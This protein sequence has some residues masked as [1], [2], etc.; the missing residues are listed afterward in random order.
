MADSYIP[1]KLYVST[2]EILKRA[3]LKCPFIRI[4]RLFTQL[5]LQFLAYF[6]L[7]KPRISGNYRE[8]SFLYNTRRL[9]TRDCSP[10]MVEPVFF[11][12]I[13]SISRLLLSEYLNVSQFAVFQRDTAFILRLFIV[14]TPKHR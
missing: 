8:H 4:E 5:S 1:R 2:Y 11:A 14:Q 7:I 10:F 12:I 13:F 9:P 6:F 3:K